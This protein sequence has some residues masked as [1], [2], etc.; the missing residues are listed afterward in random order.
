[1]LRAALYALAAAVLVL[2]APGASHVFI[3]QGF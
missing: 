3:Y 2:F 1:V